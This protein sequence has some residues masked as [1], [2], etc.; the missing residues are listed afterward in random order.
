[1]IVSLPPWGYAF[2]L[3]FHFLNRLLRSIFNDGMQRPS[4]VSPEPGQY[5]HVQVVNCLA[6]FPPMV[7][8][9]GKPVRSQRVP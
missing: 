7:Y 4:A 6:G 1:L 5:V 9:N 2:Y 8:A 3:F